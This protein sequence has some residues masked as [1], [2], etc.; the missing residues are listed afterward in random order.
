M[1]ISVACIRCGRQM[2]RPYAW[3]MRYRMRASSHDGEVLSGPIGIDC[4]RALGA[5]YTVLPQEMPE[6]PRKHSPQMELAL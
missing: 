1:P 5:N 2:L 4:A 3:V 6:K